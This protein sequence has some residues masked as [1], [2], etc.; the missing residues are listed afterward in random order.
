MLALQ[1]HQPEPIRSIFGAT[2]GRGW[3]YEMR[4]GTDGVMTGGAMY[5][6]VYAKLW[7]FYQSGDGASLSDCYSKL[8]LIQNLDNLIPGVRLWVLQKRGVWH[9]LRSQP[10]I[11]CSCLQK[12]VPSLQ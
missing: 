5:A 8:L 9:L 10:F 6:D 3:L 1:D 12:F 4:I 2:L 11:S 7:D